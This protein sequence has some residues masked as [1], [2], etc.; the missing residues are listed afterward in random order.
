MRLFRKALIA[1][2]MAGMAATASAGIPTT[3]FGTI[4]AIGQQ[5]AEAQAQLQEMIRQAQSGILQNEN[6]TQNMQTLNQL[7]SN[8]KQAKQAAGSMQSY[9][10]QFKSGDYFLNHP[11]FTLSNQCTD[12][13]RAELKQA[14]GSLIESNRQANNNFIR[15]LDNQQSSLIEETQKLQQLQTRIQEAPSR[16]AALDYNNQLLAMLNHQMLQMRAQ[17]VAG[18][19]AQTA[20][21][22]DL[23]QRD[24]QLNSRIKTMSGK[25]Q[26]TNNSTST[27]KQYDPI[28]GIY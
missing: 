2:A 13:K 9:L 27:S 3:D 24:I 10:D 15:V 11:C 23:Q 18:N 6:Y 12:E 26:T 28:T 14:A 22:T 16:K 21:Y 1:T 8:I 19:Q 4:G 5:I 7:M 25:I 17:S 20:Y